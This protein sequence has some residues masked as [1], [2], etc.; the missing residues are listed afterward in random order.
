MGWEWNRSRRDFLKDAAA[1]FA[2]LSAAGLF[3]RSPRAH[4]GVS[5]QRLITIHAPGG[6]DLFWFC[7]GLP[8]TQIDG[9]PNQEA[10]EAAFDQ[11]FADAECFQHPSVS[12][13]F[14]GLGMATEAIF[15]R[16][17]LKDDLLI[18]RGMEPAGSHG[19]GNNIINHGA[20]TSYAAS[21]ASLTANKLGSAPFSPRDLHYVQISSDFG[22]LY[23]RPGLMG[24]LHVPIQISSAPVWANSTWNSITSPGS[25]EPAQNRREA[26]SNTV[27]AIGNEVAKKLNLDSSKMAYSSFLTSFG[28]A[29]R[30]LLS[31]HA[32]SQAFQDLLNL[33]YNKIKGVFST[34]APAKAALKDFLVPT[35]VYNQMGTAN[36]AWDNSARTTAFNYALAEYLVRYD[37]S[38]VVEILAPNRDAHDFNDNQVVDLLMTF[39]CF[40]ELLKRLKSTGHLANTTVALTSEF[41]RTGNRYAINSQNEHRP[42]TDHGSTTTALLAGPRIRPGVIGGFK[43]SPSG[44]PHPNGGGFSN[45]PF[46][47]PLPIDLSTGRPSESGT[48]VT[49]KWFFPT[50]LKA[51][52]VPV[53]PVQI[54]E[55]KAL[56]AVLR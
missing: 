42:G 39:T 28:S 47:H 35:G 40:G 29:Q 31:Q 38:T 14:V 46:L 53:P 5:P 34:F 52:D 3:L 55:G 20:F 43:Q 56:A 6:W 7:N 54:S 30:V 13:A 1:S 4:A 19:I 49:T 26:I 41:D 32:Q 15:P 9:F 24:G 8:L 45:L 50:L 11:R 27:N 22:S 23:S 36:Q 21:F 33:Y 17:T 48:T 10:R 2:A 25:A 12:G 51:F 44:Q 16:A 37:I 18:W